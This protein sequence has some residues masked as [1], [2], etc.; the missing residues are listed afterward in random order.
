MKNPNVL[1][2]VGLCAMVLLGAVVFVAN[3][4]VFAQQPA[5]E[6]VFSIIWSVILFAVL[7][8]LLAVA[9][10]SKT[11]SRQEWRR[12]LYGSF[13]FIAE[14]MS[15]LI[16]LS[17]A[18]LFTVTLTSD[19]KQTQLLLLIGVVGVFAL[20]LPLGVQLARAFNR[21]QLQLQEE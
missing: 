19:V 14:M 8:R 17:A 21:R 15:V 3:R 1:V 2:A 6:N 10:R 20:A 12:N 4:V 5:I 16:L 11:G 13:I 9:L 7:Y 18:I